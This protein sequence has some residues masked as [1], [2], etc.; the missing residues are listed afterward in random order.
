MN[1]ALIIILPLFLG[2]ILFSHYPSAS[3]LIKKILVNIFMHSTAYVN[4]NRNDIK[5]I[6]I[7]FNNAFN[8]SFI[9]YSFTYDYTVKISAVATG[10][11]SKLGNPTAE[12]IPNSQRFFNNY[13]SKKDTFKIV[14][15]C[16]SLHGSTTMSHLIH[17]FNKFY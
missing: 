7:Y 17:V 15:R 6:I 3:T 10:L 2:G 12:L 1:Y 9:N 13:R 8:Q 11:I 14:N 4:M 5:N 16:N